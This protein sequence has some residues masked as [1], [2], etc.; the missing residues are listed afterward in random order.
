MDEFIRALDILSPGTFTIESDETIDN[1]AKVMVN[2]DTT[3]LVIIKKNIPVGVISH[4]DII[5]NTSEDHKSDVKLDSF[6][7]K[8]LISST[9]DTSFFEILNLMKRNAIEWIP[10]IDENKVVGA[11]DYKNIAKGFIEVNKIIVKNL[12]DEEK[13]NEKIDEIMNRILK[14][15]KMGKQL[16]EALSDLPDE[17]SV[18]LLKEYTKEVSKKISLLIETIINLTILADE[19]DI[20]DEQKVKEL[21]NLLNKEIDINNND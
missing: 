15:S 8:E 1:T 18:S 4:I 17:D 2:L 6:P 7:Y 9:A 12:R 5:K 10:I 3:H 14:S 13:I 16:T 20:H 21:D 11:I 19:I